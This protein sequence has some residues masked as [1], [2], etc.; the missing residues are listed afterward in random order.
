MRIRDTFKLAKNCNGDSIMTLKGD[1]KKGTHDVNVRVITVKL[2]GGETEYLVT[3]IFDKSLTN[4]DFK[5]LYFM[6]WP[7]LYEP[8]SYTN[9]HI[10]MPVNHKIS[11]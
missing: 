6:R 9:S 5:E 1:S 3:N 10:V 2:D 8:C 11:A 4:E 7:I